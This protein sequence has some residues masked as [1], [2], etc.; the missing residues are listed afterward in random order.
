MKIV[1]C[2]QYW[3]NDKANAM[4]L[5]RLIADLQPSWSDRF[6]FMFVPRFDSS[7][8]EQTV[9]YVSRKFNV[10]THISTRREIGWPAGCNGI[11][12]DLFMD[13][14]RRVK[15]GTWA[16]VKAVWLLEA[17]CLP[18]S[19]DWLDKIEQEWDK[20]QADGKLL[21]GAWQPEWSNVGHINGN[22]LFSPSLATVVRGLE[23]CP[24]H[25]PWDTFH[26]QKFSRHWWKSGQLVNFYKRTNVTAEE[27]WPDGGNWVFVHGIKDDSGYNL[28]RSRLLGTE[29]V[30]TPPELT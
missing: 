10:W 14:V 27:I 9:R 22:M 21:V 6:E 11:V 2:L 17:D 23:G 29:Q 28:V 8:D 12:S 25:M 5:A 7:L 16:H 18:L 19:V 15:D 1:L 4:R 30:V 26:A 20:A 13:S 24:P 3:D